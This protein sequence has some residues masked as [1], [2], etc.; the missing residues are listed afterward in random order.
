MFCHP[1][2]LISN[3]V[4]FIKPKDNLEIIPDRI[5]LVTRTATQITFKIQFFFAGRA[6]KRFII[7]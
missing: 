1:Y 7:N 4:T 2:L 3:I 5:G 6:D